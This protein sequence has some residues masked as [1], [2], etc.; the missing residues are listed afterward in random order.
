MLTDL[1]AFTL[2]AVVAVL[3]GLGSGSGHH[4]AVARRRGKAASTVLLGESAGRTGSARPGAAR[5]V[6]ALGYPG[7][8]AIY[9]PG[10]LDASQLTVLGPPDLNALSGTPSVQG[11][12]SL[13]DGRYA[14]ATG[15]HQATGDGQDVLSPGA[16][17]GGVLDQLD[18][19]A[20][21]TLPGYLITAAGAGP[22]AAGPAGTGRRDGRRRPAGHLV[23]RHVPG[24]LVAPGAGQRRRAGRGGR[25]SSG[26]SPP[27]RHTRW[28]RARAAR[29]WR[30]ASPARWRRR[31]DRGRG[32]AVR[33]GPGTRQLGPPS[34]ADAA[35]AC[36]SPM[37]S[38]RTLVPPR[39]GY[40]GLDG[41]FAV[42]ADRFA[43]GPLSP[44]WHPALASG[45]GGRRWP[46]RR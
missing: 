33:P 39:W 23:L 43:R 28:F 38:C 22:A 37:G 16:V 45:A 13:V 2:L 44:R 12:S 42:F 40:A 7:R 8:F 5:P 30:S 29:P 18:T 41:S 4:S 10:E 36:S 19:S 34:I 32:G 25:H 6:A 21:L 3:P 11:Y 35:G 15:S 27:G 17:A 14:A 20:L 1:V 24:G 31:G 26:W 46:A 9:D